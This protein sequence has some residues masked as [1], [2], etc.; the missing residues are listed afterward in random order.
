M[1]RTVT[2]LESAHFEALAA[3]LL[4]PDPAVDRSTLYL[5]SETSDFLRFNQGALRQATSVQQAYVSVAVERGQR[6]SESSLSLL[7]LIH[8]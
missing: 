1:I 2:Y 4:Q 5:C 6:R 7:S 3:A 8:I